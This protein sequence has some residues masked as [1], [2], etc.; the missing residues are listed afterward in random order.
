MTTDMQI[1]ETIEVKVPV[2]TTE[3]MQFQNDDLQVLV[4]P[5]TNSYTEYR[6]S[7]TP[8]LM[9]EASLRS[10]QS[11]S[12]SSDPISV[13]TP[14][15]QPRRHVRSQLSASSWS[16]A[17]N[18]AHVEVILLKLEELVK[19]LF[20]GH[21]QDE[22][23]PYLSSRLRRLPSGLRHNTELEI[24]QILNSAEQSLQIGEHAYNTDS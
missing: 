1:G 10:T 3:E 8:S 24:M 23:V 2:T 13:S 15:V 4:T 11:T 7:K 12:V 20:E 16:G 22:F 5:S 18:F 19:K 14:K 6:T 17:S 9:S 21:R